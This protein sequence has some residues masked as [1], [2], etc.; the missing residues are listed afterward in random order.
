MERRFAGIVL[1]VIGAI[2][3]FS[4]LGLVTISIFY[5]WP[6]FM[7]VPGLLFHVRFFMNPKQE[8]AGLLVPGGVLTV[9]GSLFLFCNFFG[10]GMM[11]ALWP[12][13]LLGPAVGL[14]ELYWFG[15]RTPGLLVPVTI[16]TVLALLFLGVN[17]LSGTFGGVLGIVLVLVGIYALFGKSKNR[18]KFF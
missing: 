6:L 15:G 17:V 2:L 11:G 5:L 18:D 14:F 13:F 8:H 9:I 12:F 3:A 4:A 16:L 10:W 1:L 7:I